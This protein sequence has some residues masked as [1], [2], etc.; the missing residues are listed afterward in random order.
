MRTDMTPGA[1]TSKCPAPD[2]RARSEPALSTGEADYRQVAADTPA[3]PR[4]TLRDETSLDGAD[5]H[6]AFPSAERESWQ[7]QAIK[8]YDPGV[9]RA[10]QTAT[11]EE[12]I[13]ADP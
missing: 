11:P 3:V 5:W 1:D 6:D 4:T 8:S 13:E 12:E 7:P 10:P 2:P 9:F